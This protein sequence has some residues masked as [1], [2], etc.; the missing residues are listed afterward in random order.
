MNL[1][2]LKKT[3]GRYVNIEIGIASVVLSFVVVVIL[4]NQPLQPYDPMQGDLGSRLEPICF[5]E[6]FQQEEVFDFG[7][8]APV[9][10]EEP[11]EEP[12]FSEKI[13]M[14]WEECIHGDYW[15]GTDPLGRDIWSRSVASLPW[16]T[17]AAGIATL[18]SLSIGTLLGILAAEFSG[19]VR[20]VIRQT[21]DTVLSFPGLVIAIVIIAVVGQGFWTLT[22]TLGFLSWP[23]FTRVVYAESLSLTRRD[24]VTA[25][26]LLG[27][28]RPAILWGHVLP[29]LRPTLFVVMAFQFANL[30]IAESALSFL[31]L[32]VPLGVPT[33]GNMMNEARGNL[34]DAPW[35][36]FVPASAIVV[37]VVTANLLGDGISVAARKKGRG[38]EL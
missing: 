6:P 29:G 35:M 38:A 10:A 18:I 11:V 22:L 16:S 33:W 21:V 25:A 23:V 4:F 32:G 12:G 24:Y 34:L 9:E 19:I 13:G 36:M 3:L 37:M 31:G 5:V 7:F 8:G 1:N 14:I 26:R 30:L 28:G 2:S 27:A 20:T 15:L 17:A